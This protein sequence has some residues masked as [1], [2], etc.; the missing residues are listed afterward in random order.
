MRG[1]KSRVRQRGGN[2]KPGKIRGN[3]AVD[4]QL[5]LEWRAVN[6]GVVL[7]VFSVGGDETL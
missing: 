6:I 5:V 4:F 1:E 7:F 3:G 2:G